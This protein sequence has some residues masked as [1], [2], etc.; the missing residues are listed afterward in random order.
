MEMCFWNRLKEG[1]CSV[2]LLF[3]LQATRFPF[4]SCGPRRQG[5]SGG[6]WELGEALPSQADALK[7]WGFVSRRYLI[8]REIL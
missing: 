7:P 6:R 4:Q 1:H 8:T 3:S 5:G 2:W